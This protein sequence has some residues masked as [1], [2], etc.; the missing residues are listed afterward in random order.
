MDTI[1]CNFMILVGVVAFFTGVSFWYTELSSN[2]IKAHSQTCVLGSEGSDVTWEEFYQ[3]G[4][5]TDIRIRT[6]SSCG[7]E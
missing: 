4:T 7:S 6:P 2:L 1:S 3:T 5:W